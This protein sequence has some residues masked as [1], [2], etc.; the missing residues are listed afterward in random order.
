MAKARKAA[1][2]SSPAG[3][4]RR[5]ATNSSETR[6]A[7]GHTGPKV[8]VK[9]SGSRPKSLA[10]SSEPRSSK[11]AEVITLLRRPEGATIAEVVAT[12]G[13]RPHTVR[14]LFSGTLKKK[15]GLTL[16]SERD[17][18]GRTYRV[19]DTGARNAGTAR[20]RRR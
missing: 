12:T 13:W 2:A 15:L 7:R 11:Q 8:R 1:E 20:K 4:R 5:G 14:G 16:A 3:R 18:R 6:K 17:E 10:V 9:R 19:I